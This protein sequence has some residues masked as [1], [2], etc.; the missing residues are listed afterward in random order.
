[1]KCMSVV[2]KYEYICGGKKGELR[3]LYSNDENER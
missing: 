1:M 3:G 2:D